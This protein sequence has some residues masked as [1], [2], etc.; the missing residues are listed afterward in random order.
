M[1]TF[2]NRYTIFLIACMGLAA[3]SHAG[4]FMF[5]DA[6]E[7]LTPNGDVNAL[8]KSAV[9]TVSGNIAKSKIGLLEEPGYVLNAGAWYKKPWTRDASYNTMF[10]AGLIAPPV[11]RNTLVG[12]LTSDDEY[13]IRIGGQYWDCVAWASGAWAYYCHT[14]DDEFLAL[15]YDAVKNSL[16]H[17]EDNEYD[18]ETGLFNGPGWSDGIAGYPMPYAETLDGSGFILKSKTM[19]DGKF[20]MKALSTNCL[21]ARAYALMAK[22]ADRLGQDTKEY[23]VK[24]AAVRKAVNDRLWMEEKGYYAYFL[25]MNGKQDTSMEALG[26]AFAILFDIAPAERVEKVLANQHVTQHGVPCTWPVYPRFGY[27]MGRHC[28]TIWPQIQ[29][30]WAWACVKSG[31]SRKFQHEFDRLTQL[32]VWTGGDFREIFDPR[33]GDPY[34]GI[35]CG[36]LSIPSMHGQTWAATAYLSMVYH[37]LFGMEFGADGIG[38]QPNPYGD[39]NDIGLKGVRLRS[40]LLDIHVAGTGRK[41]ESFKLDG[42]DHPPF[43]GWDLQGRHLIEIVM[44]K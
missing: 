35:Q 43:I 19:V 34:G 8:Y 38:F 10:A 9:E 27:D 11:A 23:S 42:K 22:M 26:H 12:V 32:V 36:S 31:D 44:E 25:D 6:P 41:I 3:G 4:E 13:G 30:F 29:G 5:V 2:F 37:G 16:R 18:P 28:G 40:M 21:Y 14:G 20:I 33:S 39:K 1:T 7:L 24:A 17:A 15:A